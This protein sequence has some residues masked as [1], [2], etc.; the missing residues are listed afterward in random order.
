ME[1]FKVVAGKTGSGKSRTLLSKIKKLGEQG[2]TIFA[3]NL[4]YN[5]GDLIHVEGIDLKLFESVE[6]M[7]N[8][9]SVE[10][11]DTK[12]IVLVVDN[13]YI[14]INS[15]NIESLNELKFNQTIVSLQL[16]RAAEI[17]EK[18]EEEISKTIF[19][20]WGIKESEID[21]DFITSPP[22]LT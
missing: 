3:V 22:Q 21:V 7:L 6:S 4:E 17:N 16:S 18:S 2:E 8:Y 13:G 5:Q 12:Q 11:V 10:K 20:R 9:I 15:S 1:S 14:N 19:S